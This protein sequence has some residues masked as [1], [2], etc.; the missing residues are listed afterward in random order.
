MIRDPIE[1]ALSALPLDGKTIPYIEYDSHHDFNLEQYWRA[2]LDMKNFLESSGRTFKVFDSTD[3]N[4]ETSEHFVKRLC[5]FGELP[6]DA[7][8]LKNMPAYEVFPKHWWVP[9]DLQKNRNWVAPKTN[10]TIDCFGSALKATSF[11]SKKS[12][13]TEENLTVQQRENLKKLLNTV[14]PIF[15]ELKLY[16]CN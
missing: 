2:L 16:C 7:E 10:F 13:F 4:A 12:V 1:C 8:S 9:P 11:S 6:F 3:L 5:E 14:E 15:K